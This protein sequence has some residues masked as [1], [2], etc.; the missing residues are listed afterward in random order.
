MC[1]TSQRPHEHAALSA[2]AAGPALPRADEAEPSLSG[3]HFVAGP[4]PAATAGVF[5]L[6]RRIGDRLY[7]ALVGE[8]EDIAA[9][10]AQAHAL[11]GQL[12][13]QTDGLLWMARANARQRAHILRELVGKF[14]PPLNVEHRNGAA[15]PAIAAFIPD[16]AD[17]AGLAPAE[18]L[19]AE[20]K[21]DE[22]DLRQLVR[23]FYAQA[24]Q[25]PMIGPVFNA[26]VADWEHHFDVVQN[27]WSRTLLG[28]ARYTG[29]PFAPHISLKLKPEF[30][31]RWIAIFKAVA[32]DVLQPEAARRAIAKVEH[33][34]VCFQTG[35]FLPEIRQAT[36]AV[37]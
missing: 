11:D 7:P 33:M 16:R 8:G 25:D 24:M 9:A 26:A 34:S 23:V 15:A 13:R 10:L 21:V 12:A 35:L 37:G 17:G 2:H 4:P 32:T 22:E 6:T 30:F 5:I 14:N 27:F 28:T 18:D 36:K 31:D 19:A 29:N 20:I 3:Y 1:Q